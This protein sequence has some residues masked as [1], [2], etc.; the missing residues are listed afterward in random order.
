MRSVPKLWP[1][2]S[3]CVCLGGGP[4]LTAE[5]AEYCRGKSYTV[6]VNDS[7]KLAAWADVLYACDAKYWDHYEGVPSFTGLKFT[8]EARAERW[9][10]VQALKRAGPHGLELDP[11]EGIAV[12]TNS[13]FQALGI[14]VQ[15][16]ATHIIL[17]GYDMMVGPHGRTHWFGK[18]PRPLECRADYNLFIASFATAVVPLREAGIRVTNCSRQTALDC[19]ER[20][21]LQEALP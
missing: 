18:H 11:A 17:L 21:P 10:G 6:A 8:L 14:A 19:F 3:V 7:H 15:L 5:D 9:P 1:V 4:S 12:G 16:G 20:M 13:G 2:N